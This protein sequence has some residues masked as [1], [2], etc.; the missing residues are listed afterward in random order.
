MVSLPTLCHDTFVIMIEAILYI[1]TPTV[2]RFLYFWRV[3]LI[4]FNVNHAS[5]GAPHHISFLPIS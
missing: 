1:P 5:P 4:S 3:R 2:G